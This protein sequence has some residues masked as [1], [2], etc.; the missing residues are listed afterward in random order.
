MS[1][2]RRIL[3]LEDRQK[4]KIGNALVVS[5]GIEGYKAAYERCSTSKRFASLIAIAGHDTDE[6]W[7]RLIKAAKKLADN[8]KTR[9]Q[10]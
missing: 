3:S 9:A 7:E 4:N 6:A 5:F 10:I 1:E 2:F 8:P